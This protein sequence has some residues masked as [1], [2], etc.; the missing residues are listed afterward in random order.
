MD[1]NY[2]LSEFIVYVIISYAFMLM[3]IKVH[4]Y[5]PYS[6]YATVSGK[7]MSIKIT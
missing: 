5:L 6:I 2:L 7:R 4:A 1:S 3:C